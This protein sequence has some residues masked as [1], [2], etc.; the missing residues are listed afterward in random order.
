MDFNF[1]TGTIGTGLQTLDVSTLPPLGGT[2][3]LLTIIGTGAVLL[4]SGTTAQRPIGLAAMLRYN[5]DTNTLEY[6]NGT[7]WASLAV[8]GGTVTSV[9]ATGSTGLSVSGGPITSSGSLTL[10]LSSQLQGLSSVTTTPGVLVQTAAGVFNARTITGTAG[11]TVVTNG[12]GVA[13][14]P[15]INLATVSQASSGNFVKVTLDTFGRVTGNTSVTTA[16]V[17]SLVDSAYVKLLGSAMSSAANITFVGGGEVLGL[18]QVPSGDTAATS[19]YYVDSAIT[20]LSWKQSARLASTV[21]LAWTYSNGASGVGATLSSAASSA[22]VDSVAVVNGDRV[23]VKNQTAQLQNGIYIVS[24]VGSTVVLTRSLQLDQPAEFSGAAVWIQTGSTQASTGWTQTQAVS[25]IGTD[26]VVWNQF[27]GS[28]TYAAGTGLS[29]TG[30][31]FSLSTPVDPTLGGTGVSTLPTAGQVL[32]GTTGGSYTPAGLTASTGITITPTSG[33]ISIANSGVLSITG[34]TNQITASASTGAIT[35]SLPT[36]ISATNL[37]LSGLTANSFV[38]TG[39]AGLLTTTAAPTNGQILIGST[40]AAPV[41]ATITQGTGITVTNGAGSITISGNTGTVTSVAVSG[42]T[43]GLTTSGGPVTTSGTITLAGTLAAAN[44]GTGLNTSAATNGQLLI[45][46]GSGLSLAA[47]TAGTGISVTNGAGSVTLANTGVTGV[48]L[49]TVTGPDLAVLTLSPTTSST[50]AVAATITFKTQTANTVFASSGGQP[51]FRALT[52]ADLSTALQL[53]KET[54]ST[55]TTPVAS[56]A[57]SV[58]IG[59]GSSATAIGSFAVGLG[60]NSR[61]FGQKSFANGTF[62]TSGDAQQGIYVARNITTTTTPTELYLDGASTQLV[63]P[64]NSLF[65]FDI[66][67]SARRT[68]AVGGGA[69]YRFVGIA[70]KDATAG[71]VTFVGTPSKTIIGETT[72]AWDAAVA[73]DTGTGAFLVRATGEAAKTIRWVATIQT[74]EVTN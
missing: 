12:D 53:Y 50:G 56:G 57:N 55:P 16:D 60:A 47:L 15:T 2:A 42:G 37:T 26:P 23:L 62:A 72:A 61:L 24:G 44:G 39:A 30:N 48:S 34:T 71:S 68:D 1:D 14:A 31:I 54:P 27:S 3:G 66:I 74:T 59:S 52:L 38:R 29:L 51:A 25:V 67:I 18:P 40:G 45:G 11:N 10:T 6:H 64:N 13:G 33:A 49:N 19:K 73:V 9:N 65:T 4:T 58:A 46:N 69:G 43:T 41:A 7:A 20:G 28:G 22:T 8:G 63:M 70:K 32:I 21:N 36:S 17:T 5:V 35:L